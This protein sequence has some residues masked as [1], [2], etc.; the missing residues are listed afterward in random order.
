MVRRRNVDRQTALVFTVALS[1]I[2]AKSWSGRIRWTH[3]TLHRKVNAVNVTGALVSE[4]NTGLIAMELGL[5]MAPRHH[6]R[7]RAPQ[8]R[9][10]LGSVRRYSLQSLLP[11]RPSATQAMSAACRQVLLLLLACACLAGTPSS[12]SPS[13]DLNGL[14]GSVVYLDFWASWCAPCREAFPWM[15]LMQTNYERQGLTVIAVN[16]DHNRADA[17]R[18]LKKFQPNFK[19]QFDPQGVLAKQFN[20]AGMPTSVLIDRH[21]VLRYTHIGFRALDRQ[22]RTN[23]IQ[24]LL[25]EK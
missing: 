8:L 6:P 7:R 25:A 21:G 14:R 19:V 23:E 12:A 20:V 24:Q 16:L 4:G 17:D 9:I 1:R 15:G 18:F 5:I 13:L 3:C 10:I 11:C 22:V 2:W